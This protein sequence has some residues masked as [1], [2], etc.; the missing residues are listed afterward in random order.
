MDFDREGLKDLKGFDRLGLADQDAKQKQVEPSLFFSFLPR[1]T[2][3][4]M[5]CNP[6]DGGNADMAGW[7]LIGFPG[8]R[9]SNLEDVDSHF[10]EAFRPNPISLCEGLLIKDE[11]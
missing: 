8:P 7:Q 4:G 10:D 9:M 5:F 1:H 3:E 6:I 2:I 11:K